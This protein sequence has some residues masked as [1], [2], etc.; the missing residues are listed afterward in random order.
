M[1]GRVN[2]EEA[3]KDLLKS[4]YF[5]I[6]HP[7]VFDTVINHA[8][9]PLSLVSPKLSN[10]SS[11]HDS[12]EGPVTLLT[13]RWIEGTMFVD[14]DGLTDG[15]DKLAHLRKSMRVRYIMAGNNVA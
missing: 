4:P 9:I 10:T 8:L 15:Y 1:L 13:P 12:E 6:W 7:R 2:S 11:H 3:R 5:Q 14:K